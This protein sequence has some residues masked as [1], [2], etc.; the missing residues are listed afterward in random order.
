MKAKS[1]GK[2]VVFTDLDGT[3]LDASSY[4]F[5]GALPGL[6]LIKEKKTPL[7]ICSSKT[8]KEIEHYRILLNNDGPF[9]AENGGGI[10]IPAGYFGSGAEDAG[11]ARARE[12]TYEIISLGIQYEILREALGELRR[13]GFDV[14]G[15]GDMSVE[16][17]TRITGLVPEQ[18][19]M[20]KERDFDE[21]FIFSGPEERI[22]D[23]EEA[24]RKKGLSLTQGK[25]L[26][27]LGGS[28]KG[29]AVAIV[30]EL[31]RKKFGTIITVGL[32]DSPNDA[33]MLEQVDCPVLVRKPGGS[34]DPRIRSAN[35]ILADGVGPEGWSE[36][37]CKI[38]HD[39]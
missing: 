7:V 22:S 15:F 2:L 19:E 26:H 36:A 14:T 1:P 30:T 38:L 29:K 6:C 13:E 34:H 21:P 17:I 16:E 20:A 8:R 23:L 3:L 9:I 11:W 31:F 33:P 28:D 25:F 5:E 24:I 4:S 39:P 12:G 37:I 35:L 10:F 18:A 32:G 27:I